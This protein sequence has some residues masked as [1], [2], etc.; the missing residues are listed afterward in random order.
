MSSIS[1]AVRCVRDKTIQNIKNKLY[2]RF[3]ADFY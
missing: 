3:Y 1:S 2:E